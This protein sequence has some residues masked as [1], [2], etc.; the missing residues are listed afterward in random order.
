M[1]LKGL[2]RVMPFI[3]S[4]VFW[5]SVDLTQNHRFQITVR[6]A[7]VLLNQWGGANDGSSHW[8]LCNSF[9]ILVTLTFTHS[10]N[11]RRAYLT[12]TKRPSIGGLC[13]LRF[14]VGPQL[15]R[16]WRGAADPPY[17]EVLHPFPF[18]LLLNCDL[19]REKGRRG[20]DE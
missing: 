12:C 18:P 9:P 7:V 2:F 13:S 4:F 3:F 11:S 8:C 14:L 16:R 15:P 1:V 10:Q 20:R 19:D 17:S 5:G 6:K